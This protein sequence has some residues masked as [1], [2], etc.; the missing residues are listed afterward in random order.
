PLT[1]TYFSYQI[2]YQSRA[3]RIS[4]ISSRGTELAA[5]ASSGPPVVS[6]QSPQPGVTLTGKPT[7]AWTAT[8]SARSPLSFIVD[9]S[10][11]GAKTWFS[12]SDTVTTAPLTVTQYT[13]DTTTLLNGSQIYFR[14]VAMNGLDSSSAS[15]GPFTIRNSPAIA[16][17]SL[18]L[19]F[20][21][22]TIGS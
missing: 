4:L 3:S 9:Y 2:P 21:S 1:P 11:D 22:A 6:I 13:F 16:V 15:I 17:A 5:F 20:G 10:I 7:L 12:L 8:D 19:D 14:V 18:A